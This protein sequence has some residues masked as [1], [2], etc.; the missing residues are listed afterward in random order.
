MSKI[1]QIKCDAANCTKV[2]QE[3]NHWFVRRNNNADMFVVEMM[4]AAIED[5]GDEHICGSKCLHAE[6]EQWITAQTKIPVAPEEG[7]CLRVQ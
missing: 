7:D 6:L 1:T 2:K 4:N 3:S 5:P